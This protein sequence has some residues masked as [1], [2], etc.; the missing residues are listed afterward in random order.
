MVPV[1][2]K[3]LLVVGF[4]SKIQNMTRVHLFICFS[5]FICFWFC[6]F[7]FWFLRNLW[8]CWRRWHDICHYWCLL[9]WHFWSSPCFSCFFCWKI[10]YWSFVSSLFVVVVISLIIV[11]SF[12]VITSLVLFISKIVSAMSFSIFSSLLSTIE[13]HYQHT[14]MMK[15]SLLKKARVHQISG[16]GLNDKNKMKDFW[17]IEGFFEMKSWFEKY[18]WT[19][20][21]KSGSWK[22]YLKDFVINLSISHYILSQGV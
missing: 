21:T 19:F 12:V 15:K 11:D 6:C 8:R 7:S 22:R 2:P 18:D 16:K 1:Q 4:P 14:R 3:K 13:L 5:F 10:H 9:C 20:K 17:E